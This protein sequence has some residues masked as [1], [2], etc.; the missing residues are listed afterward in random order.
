MEIMRILWVENGDNEN[1]GQKKWRSCEFWWEENG[2]I[3]KSGQK[4]I[5]DMRPKLLSQKS[6]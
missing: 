5:Y 6:R 1:S 2:D 4:K 3:D